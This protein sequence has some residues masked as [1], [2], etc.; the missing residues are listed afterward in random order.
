MIARRN[1]KEMRD[2][3]LHDNRALLV[4]GARQTGKTFSIRR[5]GRECFDTFVEINFY[6]Q[7]DA[8]TLFSNITSAKDIL[9]RL[10]I[11]TKKRVR[12]TG[13]ADPL[14]MLIFWV[15]LIF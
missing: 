12:G 13:S 7:P 9:M 11:L 4:E 2:F 5:V 10:S 1:E 3:F 6:E 14:P 8:L 15:L